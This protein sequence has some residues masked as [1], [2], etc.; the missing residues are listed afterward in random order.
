MSSE[1]DSV[2]D[3]S[4]VM[5]QWQQNSRPCTVHNAYQCS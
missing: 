1:S 2:S 4:V 5:P 3:W